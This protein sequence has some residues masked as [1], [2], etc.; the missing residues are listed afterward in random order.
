MLQAEPA[1]TSRFK[2]YRETHPDRIRE[3]Q[4]RY[5]AKHPE[6]VREA[7][8]RCRLNNPESE[9]EKAQRAFQNPRG[10]ANKLMCNIRKRSKEK[11]QK[12]DITLD[13][14][15]ERLALGVCQVT[16][17]PFDFETPRSPYSPSIDK[18]DPEKGYTQDNGQVVIWMYNTAKGSWSHEDVMKMVRRLYDQ[19]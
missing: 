6:R 11:G 15:E 9:K 4:A 17:F 14:L 16:G 1:P 8:R 13:W 12:Y 19:T 10:R 7:Q 5:R 18:I 2:K 3:A